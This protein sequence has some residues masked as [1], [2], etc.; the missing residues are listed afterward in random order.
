M[1]QGNVQPVMVQGAISGK[2][3]LDVEL[4]KQFMA[5]D[6]NPR[7]KPFCYPGGGNAINHNVMQ[8][9]TA[10][11]MRNVRELEGFDGE[12]AELAIVG[13]GG[14]NWQQYC[15][16]RQMEDDFYW[17][18]IVTTE[19]RMY[20]PSDP[21]TADA[22]EQGFGFIRCGT[23]TVANNGGHNF[24]PG[25]PIAWRMPRAPFANLDEPL[26]PSDLG[27]A[28]HPINYTARAGRPPTQFQIEYVPFNPLDLSAQLAAA[29]AAIT[30]VAENGGVSNFE[31]THAVPS[32]T[33][34]P[35]ERPHDNIQEEAIS[36]KFGIAAIGLSFVE[37]LI[38]RGILQAGPNLGNVAAAFANDN[39]L[40]GTAHAT[41][42]Q[43]AAD[44]GLWS[45]NAAVQRPIRTCLADVMF[46]GISYLDADGNAARGRFEAASGRNTMEVAT[47]T[48]ADDTGRF[49]SLRVHAMN[50]MV[51]GISGS[52]D[53]SQSHKVGMALNASAPQDDLHGLW[54]YRC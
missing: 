2:G 12:P 29:Y 31:Y 4:V 9:D 38:S 36:Y 42:S 51:Q 43:L 23:H 21:S 16:Q 41:T 47:R 7:A 6:A 24:Y 44:L 48:P 19:S 54:N 53:S 30:D 15:S 18:G 25:D 28:S 32:L 20:N 34:F 1:L 26:P 39:A 22:I 27:P 45:T 10:I 37:T 17:M 14:L 40:V 46:H 13:L 8:Y 33:G 52:W 35:R 49:N 5:N 11:G 50:L 3:I